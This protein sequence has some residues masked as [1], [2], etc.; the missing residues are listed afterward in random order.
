M[1]KTLFQIEHFYGSIKLF[2]GLVVQLNLVTNG[3]SEAHWT[4]KNISRDQDQAFVQKQIFLGKFVTMDGPPPQVRCKGLSPQQN[5]AIVCGSN[6]HKITFLLT[7]L[8]YTDD[9]TAWLLLYYIYTI[10][11]S[12][13]LKSV[14]T[15]LFK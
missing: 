5:Y 14:S 4:H 11:Y 10:Y 7:E 3:S 12:I 15:E 9:E 1:L 2:F 8:I 13:S 6:T